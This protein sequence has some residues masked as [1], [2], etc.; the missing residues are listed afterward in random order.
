MHGGWAGSTTGSNLIASGER[1]DGEQHVASGAQHVREQFIV[2]EEQCTVF[3]GST[4]HVA[5]S[6]MGS[7][8]VRVAGGT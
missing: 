2:G 4:L 8:I 6:T 5:C 7:N 3:A 1:H